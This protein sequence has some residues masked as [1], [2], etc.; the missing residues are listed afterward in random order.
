MP[1]WTANLVPVLKRTDAELTSGLDQ[2]EMTFTLR[3]YNAQK[4]KH[5]VFRVLFRNDTKR[6]RDHGDDVDEDE[7]VRDTPGEVTV[8]VH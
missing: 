1:A 7:K 5:R 8:P 2:V 4:T 6:A 3:Q